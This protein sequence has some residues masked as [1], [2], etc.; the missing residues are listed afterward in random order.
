MKYFPF[1]SFQFYIFSQPLNRVVYCED[2]LKKANYFMPYQDLNTRKD[3]L[4]RF[5]AGGEV[6]KRAT[7]LLMLMSFIY[8]YIII[9]IIIIIHGFR[10]VLQSSVT[11][12]FQLGHRN[13]EAPVMYWVVYDKEI[14]YFIQH[15]SHEES[16]KSAIG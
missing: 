5:S 13:K 15:R 12:C 6:M 11:S 14:R 16:Q 1:C 8:Q 2:F 4:A 9:I 7:G 3:E 10:D